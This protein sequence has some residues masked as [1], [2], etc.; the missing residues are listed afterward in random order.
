MTL[1]VVQCGSCRHFDRERRDGNFCDA[2]PDGDGIPQEIINGEHDHRESYPG[3]EG[4]RW[5][6]L[7]PDARHPFEEVSE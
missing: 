7:T 1:P 4:V 5:S 2:F 3:D 6:P